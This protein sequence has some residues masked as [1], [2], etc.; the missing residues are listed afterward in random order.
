MIVQLS[1]RLSSSMF[2]DQDNVVLHDRTVASPET[3]RLRQKIYTGG[4]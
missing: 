1:I 4:V 2:Q 3:D